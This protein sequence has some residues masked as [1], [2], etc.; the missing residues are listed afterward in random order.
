MIR[1]N[2]TLPCQF[3]VSQAF[4]FSSLWEKR[5]DQSLN[6]RSITTYPVFFDVTA[7][8][9]P[10]DYTRI[11]SW[12]RFCPGRLLR[13]SVTESLQKIFSTNPKGAPAY[14][15]LLSCSI[16]SLFYECFGHK[17]SKMTRLEPKFLRFANA[18]G[19]D[20]AKWP[21]WSQ[22]FFVLQIFWAYMK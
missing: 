6:R 18:L 14:A 8:E 12:Y 21:V 9:L 4:W 13:A 16:I 20:E 17:R 15:A 22:N 7:L 11:P 10:I 1:K 5:A 3:P 19:T 2:Y